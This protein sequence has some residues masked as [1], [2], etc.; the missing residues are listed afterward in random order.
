MKNSRTPTKR[1]KGA[2]TLIELLVVI[3]IIAILAALLL[4]GLAKA[5]Q[6]AMQTKC[7]TNLKQL[8]LGM[9][10]YLNEFQDVYPGDASRNT[11]GFQPEDWIY[12]RSGAYTDVNNGVLET[13]DKSPV[14]AYLGTKATTNLFRC[15]M[16]LTDTGRLG[17]YGDGQPIYE[18][19][20]SI[21]SYGDNGSVSQ[22][23]TSVLDDT[24]G[25]P[26]WYPFKNGSVR[27]PSTKLSFVEEPTDPPNDT[28]PPDS[29]PT[30]TTDLTID[31]GRWV[32][33]PTGGNYLTTRHNGFA[34]VGF[35]DCH[36][37]SVKWTFGTNEANT[38]PSQ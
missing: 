20:Y 18:F 29:P 24:S 17:P 16:D 12:W 26:K 36:V 14:V 33:A 31:D 25:T 23:L 35:V 22:G 32:P 27:N 3:A 13:V 28:P 10:M 8:A 37:N 38:L 30:V 7:K 19:S 15:P 11:Y 9:Q 4:P 34:D 2:F 5:K 6:Q 21:T 1:S